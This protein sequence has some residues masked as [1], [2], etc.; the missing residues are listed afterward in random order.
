VIIVAK[1]MPKINSASCR[2][3]TKSCRKRSPVMRTPG[4]SKKTG[5]SQWMRKSFE[6]AY[7]KCTEVTLAMAEACPQ[8][9]RVRWHYYCPVWGG[10]EH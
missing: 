7:G 9:K 4:M 8:L 2:N 3:A 5:Y 6:A 1:K 10:H